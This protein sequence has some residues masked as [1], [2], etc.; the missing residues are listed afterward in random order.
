MGDS[1][2]SWL[3]KR[4]LT[5]VVPTAIRSVVLDSPSTPSSDRADTLVAATHDM[6][7]RLFD[8]CAADADC[9]V[10]YPN[11]TERTA[12]LLEQ[13]AAQPIS[14]GDISIGS[15]ELIAQLRDLSNTRANY[16][17]RM[18]AELEAGETATYLALLNG[19]VGG[20]PPGGCRGHFCGVRGAQVRGAVPPT[21][22]ATRTSPLARRIAV[23]TP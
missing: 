8:D 10:A 11:L 17:P 20:E 23:S 13:L 19:E 3:L 5:P 4:R 2:R 12:A 16:V 14:A 15:D 21:P 6:V 7:L 1:F 9:S 22:A 18:I